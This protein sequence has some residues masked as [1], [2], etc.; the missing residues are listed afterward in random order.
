M[1]NDVMWAVNGGPII[2]EIR[3]GKRYDS[4]SV[5]AEQYAEDMQEYDDKIL[6]LQQAVSECNATANQITNNLTN[7]STAY[8]NTVPAMSEEFTDIK[9]S[10]ANLNNAI[11]TTAAA[12][13]RLETKEA[14]DITAVTESISTITAGLN[15]LSGLVGEHSVAI[16][17]DEA[18]INQVKDSIV[19]VR[20]EINSV[21]NSLAS[22]SNTVT[23]LS[24]THSV[25]KAV[26][27]EK[28]ANLNAAVS[29]LQNTVSSVNT[30]LSGRIDSLQA[31]VSTIS[32]EVS[33]IKS[34]IV[35]L[36]NSIDDEKTDIIRVENRMTDYEVTQATLRNQVLNLSE[37]VN[38][39]IDVISNSMAVNKNDIKS[40][41]TDLNEFKHSTTES[42]SELERRIN[43]NVDIL[44]LTAAPNICE[45]GGTE[46]IVV[47]WTTEG[48]IKSQT[49]NGVAVSGNSKTFNS[50]TEPV[51][52]TLTVTAE[53]GKSKSKSVPIT[54]INHIYYGT[55]SRT[56]ISPSLVKGLEYDV[57]EDNPERTIIVAVDNEYIY[58]AYPKRFGGV[59]FEVG[60]FQG[61]FENPVT[62]SVSNHSEYSED[63][64]VYRSTQKLTGTIRLTIRGL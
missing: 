22:L 14:G 9:I 50:V 62:V 34:N 32:S 59:I 26:T 1:R 38:D 40:L 45:I 39:R 51:V 6:A 12:L 33:A 48:I 36:S 27:D 46:N 42:I 30:L 58:Y 20:S 24:R 35:S 3:H 4:G 18:A 49:I 17:A 21:S 57:F 54:F 16:T 23:D 43:D 44:T 5:S 15:A 47:N 19:S 25:D 55:D 29:N 7:L 61:G 2:G 11:N 28:I 41:D 10:V 64:Y 63:Y 13:T 60:M 37:S 8:N 52:Y 56:V 31:S 53:N